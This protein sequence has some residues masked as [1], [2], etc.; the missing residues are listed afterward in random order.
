MTT[1]ASVSSLTP[2]QHRLAY[3]QALYLDLRIRS[4]SCVA[5][6]VA[7]VA[8]IVRVWRQAVAP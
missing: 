8:C 7:L 2:E 1:A 3:E 5:V 6:L 4:G